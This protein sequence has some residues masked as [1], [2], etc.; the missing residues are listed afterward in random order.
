MLKPG[1]DTRA[2]F[3]K[4]LFL[5]VVTN[6]K[7]SPYICKTKH[8]SMTQTKLEIN[9]SMT[10]KE[11]FFATVMNAS[12]CTRVQAEKV[13]SVY[14]KLKVIKIGVYESTY[15]IAHGGLYDKEV[16]LKAINM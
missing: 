10:A 3:I 4:N 14:K 8:N 9:S 15:K 16:I 1:T 5:K 12:G 11:K 7:Y 13:F 2:F 6:I